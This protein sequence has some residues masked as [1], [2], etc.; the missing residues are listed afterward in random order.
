MKGIALTSEDKIMNEAGLFLTIV[1]LT[2]ADGYIPTI[3]YYDMQVQR[4]ME[5]VGREWNSDERIRWDVK[6]GWEV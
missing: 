5:H 1:R 2:E 4:A 3:E 6:E